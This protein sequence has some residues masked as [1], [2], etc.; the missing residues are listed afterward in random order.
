MDAGKRFHAR[1]ES[2]GKQNESGKHRECHSF[3]NA[4]CGSRSHNNFIMVYHIL[5]GD[6]LAHS[7]PQAKIDGAVI[8]VREGLIEG[9]LS[10]ESLQE[11]WQS[12]AEYQGVTE[13]EYQYKVVSE[14]DR[15]MRAPD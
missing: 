8:V 15:L 11:F 9:S 7:F 2:Y 5:N 1:T 3:R 14:F 4:I 12:R 13:D 10:G 6:A